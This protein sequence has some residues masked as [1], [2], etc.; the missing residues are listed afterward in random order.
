MHLY[1]YV[2]NVRIWLRPFCNLQNFW[3][4]RLGN[5]NCFHIHLLLQITKKRRMPDER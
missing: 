5:D 2:T 1:Q 3:R 4:T